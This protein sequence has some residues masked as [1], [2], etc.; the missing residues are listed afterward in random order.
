MSIE[1][2]KKMA[3]DSQLFSFNEL[4]AKT[5]IK[6]DIL[7]VIISRLEEQGF[8]ERI[9]RGKYL[10][11]PLGSEKGGYTL[12]EFV[13]GSCLVKPYAIG[14][15][16]ALHHYGMT[17]QI[18]NTVFIQTPARKKNR[19]IDVF[20]ISYQIVRIN[21]EKYFGLKREWIENIAI[22]ITDKE[23][24]VID[25]LDKPEYSGGVIEVVKALKNDI[26]NA[27]KMS[28]YAKKIDNDAVV[29]RLGYLCEKMNI[30][31]DL[32]EIKSKNYLSLDP[33][34][35]KKGINNWKWRLV[36]NL[37]IPSPGA[38]E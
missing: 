31:I 32:P 3:R 6:K 27:Q 4:Y 19:L 8:I 16:S 10:I 30:S 2:L 29:R 33:T 5:K 24:T 21:E 14:Y 12:H 26:F 17:E 9:E 20:G 22:S 18:P 34:M 11:I 37:D 15:W 36:I 13:I 23:K 1:I 25:C 38:L 35:P 7:W 28:E